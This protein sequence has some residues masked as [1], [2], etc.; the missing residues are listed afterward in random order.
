MRADEAIAWLYSLEPRGIRLELD[1]LRAVLAMRG[2][3]QRGLRSVHIAGTNG[4]GSVAAMCEH[5]LRVDGGRTGLFTSPHLHRFAERIRVAGEPI[6]DDELA[7]RATDVR[8]TLEAP[9]TPLLTFFETATLIALEAFRDA[10][11]DVA[12]MEVGLGG[13]LDSTNVI[14]DPIVSVVTGVARDHMQFLGHTIRA[15]AHEKA[16]ILRHG[17][18]CVTGARGEALEVIAAHA[19]GSGAPLLWLG[20][21]IVL[22]GDTVHLTSPITGMKK[23]EGLQVALPGVHQRDNAA[24]AVAALA[25]AGVSSDAIRAGVRDVRWPGRLEPVPGFL[26]DAAHN[27]EGCRALAAYLTASPRTGKRVLLFSAMIDKDLGEMLAALA[28]TVD[29]IVYTRAR[30]K[31]AAEPSDLVGYARG[32]VVEDPVEALGRATAIAERHGLVVVAG[33]LYL[34]GEIRARVLGLAQE[35]P[36]AM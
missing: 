28:P 12:I 22:E 34:L 1:R 8:R 6:A 19:G 26:F 18:P 35:P 10:K 33:S 24:L 29:H 3:P 14:D 27:E 4:K 5:A 15:I 31:R 17:V 2:D 11:V 36:I 21:E 13:R 16:G 30:T 9:G 7:A 23:I 32:D 25:I 20:H